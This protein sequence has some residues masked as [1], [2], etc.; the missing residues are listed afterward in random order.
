M[1]MGRQAERP[2]DGSDLDAAADGFVTVTP[3]QL[4]MTHHGSLAAL[5]QAL[6]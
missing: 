6:G 1:A 5:R 4:D 3:L 2:S